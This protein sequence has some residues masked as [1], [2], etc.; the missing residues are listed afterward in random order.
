MHLRIPPLTCGHSIYRQTKQFSRLRHVA[1]PTAVKAPHRT[2]QRHRHQVPIINILPKGALLSVRSFH[3]T[4]P[5]SG[6]Q[7]GSDD[8]YH[9]LPFV[10]GA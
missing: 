4:S 5:S 2:G 9:P 1:G 8:S 7:C 3:S 10:L 6:F